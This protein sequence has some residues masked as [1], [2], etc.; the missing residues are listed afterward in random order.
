MGKVQVQGTVT[1]VK[2]VPKVKHKAVPG[3]SGSAGRD[4]VMP[5]HLVV[6]LKDYSGPTAAQA[7][8]MNNFVGADSKQPTLTIWI[9]NADRESLKPGMEIRVKGYTVTGDEGGTWTSHQSLEI[10]SRAAP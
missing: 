1:Q 3:M 2:W 7:R 4:R 8:V 9:T 10:L 5:A 6:T